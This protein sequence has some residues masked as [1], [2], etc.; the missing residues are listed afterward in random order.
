[1]SMSAARSLPGKT[2]VTT[3][4]STTAYGVRKTH[5]VRG[6]GKQLIL[7]DEKRG[8]RLII[9]PNEDQDEDNKDGSPH[10]PAIIISSLLPPVSDVSIPALSPPPLPPLPPHPPLLVL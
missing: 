6:V 4:I 3:T 2:G 1:M 9:P 8:C 5:P 7:P 10:C